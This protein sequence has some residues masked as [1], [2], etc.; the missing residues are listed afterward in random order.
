LRTRFRERRY[1]P[2]TI[3]VGL[4]CAVIASI[5]LVELG[6]TSGADTTF[7]QGGATAQA[8]AI[9]VAPTT[10]GLNYAIT[11]ATSIAAY[12]NSE[13][14]ALSQTIDLGAIGT[15]LEAPGCSGGPPA[16][17][18]S[19][20]PPPVQAESTSGNQ[21]VSS[22]ITAQSS[23]Y[24][25][26]LGN[27]SANATTQPA[28]NSTTTVNSI[29]VPGG[30]LTVSGLTSSAQASID[31][32]ATRTATATSDIGQI[33]LGGGAVVLGGL[34]WQATNQTGAQSTSSGT[35]SIGSLK[36][37]GI[38]VSTSV[39]DAVNPQTVLN[40]INTAL[41]PIGLNIQWPA[42]TTLADGTVQI[43]PL[44]I[45]IDN[46]TLGQEVVGSN[47]N[48]VQPLREAL[49]NAL[50]SANCQFATPVTVA[51]IGI[52]VLAGG[53]NLNLDLGGAKAVTNDTAPVNPF[54]SGA[55]SAA[56]T[57]LPA[58]NS[59]NSGSGFTGASGLGAST[60]PAVP[61]SATAVPTSSAPQTTTGASGGK[62]SLGPIQKTSECYSLGPA[63]GGCY[64]GNL[65]VPIGLGVIVLLS[66]LFTWDYLRQRRRMQLQGA[67][68][69]SL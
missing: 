24:G 47:L 50:L 40:I 16:L 36:V 15:A 38:P 23:P 64:T 12:Q 66:T 60:L 1:T 52:G 68:E 51:D 31:N 59:G 27:E 67:P 55:L 53:G 7:V 65:A 20:V 37:G 28:G 35:F 43:S 42:M 54:G 30:I 49:I 26:G 34:H 33:A 22:T 18:P 9:S 10:G 44:V 62:E 39:L 25:L 17:P 14:Q 21:S 32:G 41:S 4:G 56:P 61:L 2:A 6:S 46:N 13:A 5:C 69:V 48:T 57:S 63:G 58:G 11:L 45:G 29:S 19:D 8:Q 3:R